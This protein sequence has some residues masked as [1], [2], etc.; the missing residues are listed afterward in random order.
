MIH[1]RHLCLFLLNFYW[2]VEPATSTIYCIHVT[3]MP[4]ELFIT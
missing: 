3:I 1:F 2:G 4:R